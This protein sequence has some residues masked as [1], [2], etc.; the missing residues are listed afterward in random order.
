MNSKKELSNELVRVEVSRREIY[1]FKLF[2]LWR[3]IGVEQ[4][5]DVSFQWPSACNYSWDKSRPT[6]DP[7]MDKICP[8]VG[9]FI[10][11][12]LFLVIFCCV[13]VVLFYPSLLLFSA[14]ALSSA[15]FSSSIYILSPSEIWTCSGWLQC[16]WKQQQQFYSEIRQKKKREGGLCGG[17]KE[18]PCF[19]D[20]DW[21]GSA[22]LAGY[23][24]R[25]TDPQKTQRRETCRSYLSIATLPLQRDRDK[26]R[27]QK[28]QTSVHFFMRYGT[29]T[30]T[31]NWEESRH[32]L[33][34]LK[35]F[36]LPCTDLSAS[37]C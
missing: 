33:W 3:L 11:P 18:P 21:T 32:A 10:T 29:Y 36:Q 28:K 12:F 25:P 13:S 31:V 15:A 16:S 26:T 8:K 37:Q 24:A 22:E 9:L 17:F 4:H 5:A 19:Q 35:Y 2:N 1:I 27:D 14:L 34:A 30:S 6:Y 23:L 20:L 7:G